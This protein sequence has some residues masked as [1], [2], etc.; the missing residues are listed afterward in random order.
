MEEKPNTYEVL[1]TLKPKAIRTQYLW[2]NAIIVDDL[3]PRCPLI[4]G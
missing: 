2:A 4:E 3:D 1:I